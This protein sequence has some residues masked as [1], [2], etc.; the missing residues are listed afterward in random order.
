MKRTL[1]IICLLMGVAVFQAPA[2]IP[3]PA[4]LRFEITVAPGLISTPVS[5]RLLVVMGRASQPEPRL[6]V[7]QTGLDGSP[8]L[9]RDVRV[10]RQQRGR[11]RVWS[12]SGD[13]RDFVEAD[14]AGVRPR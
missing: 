11:E 12:P 4:E 10:R 1:L 8:V 6:T 9:G 7:G 13:D 5:G 3:Q 14:A 2:R